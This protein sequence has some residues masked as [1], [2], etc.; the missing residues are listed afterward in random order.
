MM[1]DRTLEKEGYLRFFIR[2]FDATDKLQTSL[3]TEGNL[4]EYREAL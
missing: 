2:S 1:R 4:E 3:F